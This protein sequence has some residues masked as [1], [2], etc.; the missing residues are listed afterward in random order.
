M[1]DR[2]RGKG[3]IRALLLLLFIAGIIYTIKTFFSSP[4]FEKNQPTISLKNDIYWNLLSPLKIQISDD[5]GLKQVKIFLSDGENEIAI[6]QDDFKP[7]MKKFIAKVS[8]PKLGL[9]K[10][11]GILKLT[12]KTTDISK[13][14][15]FTGNSSQQQSIIRIDEKKPDL[16]PLIS[17]YGITKGG[18]GLAIFKANDENLQKLYIETNFGK[19][20]KPTPFHKKGYY[21]VL[22][23]WPMTQKRFSAKIVAI[24][25]AGNKSRSRLSFFLKNK[26]YRTSTIEAKESFING[27][28]S[29]LAEDRPERTKDL[30]PPQKL[31]FINATYR[32][33][34]NQ[35][36]RKVTSKVDQNIL[37][38]FR[39][40]PFYPL[41]NGQV[42]ASF[43]DH[44]YYKYKGAVISEAYH[45]GLDLASTKMADLLVT[46]KGVTVYANYNGIYGNNLI[47]YH[48][49]GLYS[50]YGHC[51]NLLVQKGDIIKPWQVA[52]KSGATGL[53][54][55][56]HLHFSILIQGVFV[57]PAEWMD[58]KWM[59]TNITDVIEGA[60]KMIDR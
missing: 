26:K 59:Q 50:L 11:K 25:K 33:E 44:R 9:S 8:F 5:S 43:G 21:A 55:G 18:A 2:R 53:A 13:W 19:E 22:V 41:K 20:F 1:R 37:E 16:F 56:D 51:S 34:N 42:V 57:R 27:K 24:D 40:E 48:G 52:A 58:S 49:L 29:D 47:V 17:S 54:L 31:D 6:P 32:G 23:A 30:T 35:I 46:N 38:D 4:L 60:K 45:L 36:I 3:Y 28:I 15:F 12:V 39:L 14:N 7:T 10:D